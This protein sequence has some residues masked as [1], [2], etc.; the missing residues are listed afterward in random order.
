MLTSAD[1][2]R[3][4]RGGCV[5]EECSCGGCIVCARS[6][7]ERHGPA[8][9]VCSGRCACNRVAAYSAPAVALGKTSSCSDYRTVCVSCEA[10]GISRDILAQPLGTV[11]LNRLSIFNYIAPQT[12]TIRK[13][14]HLDVRHKCPGLS[15]GPPCPQRCLPNTH[16]KKPKAFVTFRQ[17]PE[18]IRVRQLARGAG[19]TPVNPPA[20]FR[21]PSGALASC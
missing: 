3:R 1:H 9:Y 14:E 2:R 10:A 7:A 20:R 12:V 16:V 6:V 19:R 15:F 8:E 5:C 18:I 21:Q 11:V 4:P 17:S 13:L